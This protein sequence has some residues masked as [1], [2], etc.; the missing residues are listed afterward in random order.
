MF[1]ILRFIFFPAK[2]PLATSDLNKIA[3]N[4]KASRMAVPKS[5][6]HAAVPAA[7]PLGH[8]RII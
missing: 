8:I 5:V 2:A 1:G 4:K 6:C 7:F 3:Q